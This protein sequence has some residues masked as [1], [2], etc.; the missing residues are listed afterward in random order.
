M[1]KNLAFPLQMS[2]V[3]VTPFLIITKSLLSSYRDGT[4]INKYQFD[5]HVRPSSR[6]SWLDDRGLVSRTVQLRI[7]RRPGSHRNRERRPRNP[8]VMTRTVRP[9]RHPR[10]LRKVEAGVG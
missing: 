7:S 5:L 1:I 6:S 2:P 4:V 10:N 3:K 8:M 9:I